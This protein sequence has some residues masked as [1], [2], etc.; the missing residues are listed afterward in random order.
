MYPQPTS[1]LFPFTK[2]QKAKA[3]AQEEVPC[4][5]QS[6]NN[7]PKEAET[8]LD[9]LTKTGL[10][11]HM[12]PWRQLFISAFTAGMEVGFS[13]LLMGVLYTLLSS[14]VSAVGMRLIIAMAYPIGFLFVVIGRSELFTEHTDLALLPVLAGKVGISSLFRLWGTIFSGNLLGGYLIG[15]MLILIGP[16]LGIINDEALVHLAEKMVYY[17]WWVILSSGI[18]AGWLMGLLTWLVGASQE[19]ISRMLAV[20]LVTVVIGVAGL[21]HSI[22]GSI[23]VFCGIVISPDLSVADYLHFQLWA[24]VGNVIGGGVF[25][26]LFKYGQING[27]HGRA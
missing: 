8:I 18:L 9:E 22:V 14:E 2:S 23:E 5:P 17:Q 13:V 16:S 15:S 27:A 11:E 24:T 7:Q 25:V 12:R 10:D 19:T 1:L 3:R 4:D 20:I 6:Q 26:G 21:H